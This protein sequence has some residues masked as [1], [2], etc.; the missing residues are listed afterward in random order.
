MAAT[1][2]EP[3]T[4]PAAG[5]AASDARSELVAEAAGGAGV[6]LA[7]ELV[8]RA[9]RWAT[10]WYL[11][12]ALGAA[13]FGRWSSATTL[14]LVLGAPLP[15]GT[16]LGMVYFGA[17]H[18]GRGERT[19]WKGALWTGAALAAGGSLA[20]GFLLWG[21]GRVWLAGERPELAGDLA[22]LV[23]ALAAWGLL[24]FLVG[25]LRAHRAMV[26]QALSYQVVLPLG[27]LFGT[28]LAAHFGLG[29]PGVFGALTLATLG[30]VG[31]VGWQ[32]W[33]RTRDLWRDRALVGPWMPRR[34]LRW[35]LPQSLETTLFRANQWMDLLMLTA[36][37]APLVVGS[38]RV[39]LALALL[40]Q[41]PVMAL[42]TVLNPMLAALVGQGERARLEG[43]VRAATR[44]LIVL[45][46]PVALTLV[47]V[48][49]LALAIFDRAYLS[50]ADSLR[51]LVPG[52]AL[53]AVYAP[54]Q[55]L[56]PMSGHARLNL[57]DHAGAAL[58][59]AGLNFMLIPRLGMRGA[60]LATTVSLVLWS[61]VSALQV[62]HL[63]G[64]SAWDRR[65]LALGGAALGLGALGLAVGAAAPLGWRL[66]LLALGCLAFL[67]VL[68][69]LGLAADDRH[70][71]GLLRARLARA[72]APEGSLH[73]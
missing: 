67:A 72:V 73:A 45:V 9:A 25:V 33:R 3:G 11:S 43:L 51:L 20:G 64:C 39:V 46:A 31:L 54:T 2:P 14:L 1:P 10:T 21:A 28:A 26:A 62:R 4:P 55:R 16:D 6:V 41:I 12:G 52:V 7:A 70:V 65:N 18:L 68:R 49:D 58:F 13:L 15:L 47:L 59:N 32:G 23:P 24:L 17:Q 50:G 57:L 42:V 48:P 27:T 29:L 37:T 63:L 44:W 61:L 56:I 53:F 38:Y 30:T 35:C 8:G 5:Q 22:L 66:A 69:F 40:C 36:L 19:A 71:L 60:A 34:L